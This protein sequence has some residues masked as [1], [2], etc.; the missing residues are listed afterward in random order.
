LAGSVPVAASGSALPGLAFEVLRQTVRP[1]VV[2]KRN[3]CWDDVAH[4]CA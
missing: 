1:L 2:R 4:L 3:C